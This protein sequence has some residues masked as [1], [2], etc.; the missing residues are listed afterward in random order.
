LLGS[1]TISGTAPAE[2][3]CLLEQ[4]QGGKQS[5]K[6][7]DE[8]RIFLQDG[9]EVTFTGVCGTDEEALVGFGTVSGRIEP[10]L[11]LGY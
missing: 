11:S 6:V 3:G 9:D 5:I 4:T 1:G 2:N 7:G 10:A 8:E